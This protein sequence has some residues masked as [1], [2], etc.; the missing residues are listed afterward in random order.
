[1]ELTEVAAEI[2]AGRDSR[3]RGRSVRSS[4]GRAA[5]FRKGSERGQLAVS[6][7][8]PWLIVVLRAGGW[9]LGGRTDSMTNDPV[10]VLIPEL[11]RDASNQSITERSNNGH[12]ARI[13]KF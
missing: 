10:F 2:A 5:G 11:L 1:M 7:I 8:C 12:L 13:S 6:F 4:D 9:R 3:E